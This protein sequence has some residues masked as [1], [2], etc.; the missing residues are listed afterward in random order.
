MMNERHQQLVQ[1]LG[2]FIR[3]SAEMASIRVD[4]TVEFTKNGMRN[5]DKKR[6]DIIARPIAADKESYMVEVMVTG[7]RPS[8]HERTKSDK[9]KHLARSEDIYAFIWHTSGRFG[10]RAVEMLEDKLVLSHHNKLQLS[11]KFQKL[12]NMMYTAYIKKLFS[13][14][15]SKAGQC[16]G[17][18]HP[19]V[20]VNV[21][22]DVNVDDVNVN[23][24][25]DNDN[26]GNISLNQDV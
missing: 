5:N 15:W 17:Y 25:N 14:A 20:G 3:S 22:I 16:N 21:A 6:P 18:G 13:E 2:Q 1:L 24:V 11:I 12:Q 26:V 7:E 4:R 8:T 19:P 9:Y 10:N 23:D